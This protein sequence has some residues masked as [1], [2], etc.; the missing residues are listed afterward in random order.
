MD[1]K[2]STDRA[3]EVLAEHRDAARRNDAF[4]TSLSLDNSL[5]GFVQTH[6]FDASNERPKTTLEWPVSNPSTPPRGGNP[7]EPRSE[8]DRRL[9]C[10]RNHGHFTM[11]FATLQPGMTPL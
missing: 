8:V 6:G 11:A 4:M 9:T 5:R 1:Q 7:S 3:C 2:P 10:F